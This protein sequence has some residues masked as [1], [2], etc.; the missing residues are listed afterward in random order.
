[1]TT[2][3]PETP[4]EPVFTWR[5]FTYAGR[6]WKPWEHM[7]H[8]WEGDYSYLPM[9]MVLSE[10]IIR[11]RN[12]DTYYATCENDLNTRWSVY[13]IYPEQT[14]EGDEGDVQVIGENWELPDMKQ[15]IGEILSYKQGICIYVS[16][17]ETKETDVENDIVWLDPRN[18]DDRMRVE[19]FEKKP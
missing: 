16:R 12:D 15:W 1:M 6:T 19:K 18:K 3:E 13:V 14:E 4:T 11:T 7:K 17:I 5:G 9:E 2:T 10:Y 8:V